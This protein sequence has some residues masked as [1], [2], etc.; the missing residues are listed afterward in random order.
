MQLVTEISEELVRL[1][2]EKLEVSS[3]SLTASN[4]SKLLTG[5]VMNLSEVDL[6]Y[7]FFETEKNF[8]VMINQQHLMSYGFCSICQIVSSIKQALG[9]EKINLI[10]RIDEI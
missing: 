4:W 1:I 8:Q 3:S 2:H 9:E 7:L 5:S 10:T 6:V